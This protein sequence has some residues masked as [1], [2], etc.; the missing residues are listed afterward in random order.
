[1]VK[2]VE[3]FSIDAKILTMAGHYNHTLT[4]KMLQIFLKGGGDGNEAFCFPLCALHER[5]EI[6]LQEIALKEK[7][8]AQ[9]HMDCAGRLY[10]DICKAVEN[11]YH[12]LKDSSEWP[13]AKHAQDSRALPSSFAVTNL[14]DIQIMA[15]MQNGFAS[16]GVKLGLCNHCKKPD[17][18][19]RECPELKKGRGGPN[20]NN[21]IKHKDSSGNNGLKKGWR[22]APPSPGDPAVKTIPGNSK[23]FRWCAK[24]K[25]W[26]TTHDTSGLRA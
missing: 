17:H 10:T 4:L 12:R 18:S 6:A 7:G 24:C 15:L 19:K 25:R 2:L 5:L 8:P 1:M 21:C 26:S 11:V 20:H 9:T 3:D 13:P 22:F 14:S 16:G 23:P